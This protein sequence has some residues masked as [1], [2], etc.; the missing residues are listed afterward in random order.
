MFVAFCGLVCFVIQLLSNIRKAQ[1]ALVA[2]DMARYGAR[3][4]EYAIKHFNYYVENFDHFFDSEAGASS[5]TQKT[6]TVII[7]FDKSGRVRDFAY[8][9]SKF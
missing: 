9:T 4:N 8:H 5:T 3:K 7:K 1:S 2:C 6:L